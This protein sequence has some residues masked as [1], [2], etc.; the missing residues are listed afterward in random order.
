[1]FLIYRPGYLAGTN[2]KNIFKKDFIIIPTKELL[3]K[4][5]FKRP[6]KAGKYNFYF[7][8][9]DNKISEVREPNETIR[10]NPKAFDYSEYLNERGWKL[11]DKTLT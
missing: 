2:K 8:L 7:R 9:Q 3:K 6:N 10:R 11:I 5:Q 1:M 4:L